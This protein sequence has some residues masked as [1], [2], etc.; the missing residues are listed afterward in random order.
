MVLGGVVKV[1]PLDDRIIQY[2]GDECFCTSAT[3]L[4]SEAY[5]VFH[6]AKFTAARFSRTELTIEP[7]HTKL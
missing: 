5:A 1:W 7:L 2:L 4:W 3:R 6:P